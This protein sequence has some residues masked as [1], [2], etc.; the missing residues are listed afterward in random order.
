MIFPRS[1]NGEGA[2]EPDQGTLNDEYFFNDNLMSI[3]IDRQT[4]SLKI[5]ETYLY[6]FCEIGT[7]SVTFDM[8]ENGNVIQFYSK[9]SNMF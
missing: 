2:R 1:N 4:L 8:I 3:N 9:Q 7:D 5:K 6:I